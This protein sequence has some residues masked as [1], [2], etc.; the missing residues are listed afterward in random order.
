M[1]FF[2]LLISRTALD[3]LVRRTEPRGNTLF[4]DA[5]ATAFPCLACL[6][7]GL[8]VPSDIWV[9]KKCPNL[10]SNAVVLKESPLFVNSPRWLLPWA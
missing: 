7:I 3:A 2:A 4:C 5:V 9:A 10:H 8:F 1:W 6:L